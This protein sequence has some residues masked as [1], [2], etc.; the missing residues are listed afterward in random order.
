MYVEPGVYVEA[1]FPLVA[2]A[3]NA[4]MDATPVDTLPGVDAAM[5][6]RPPT[7]DEG[8]AATR[9]RIRLLAGL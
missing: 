1:V 3:M 2:Q 4:I 8:R 7:N 5:L 9:G 6:L